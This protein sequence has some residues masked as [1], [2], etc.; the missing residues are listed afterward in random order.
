MKKR[1][2]K[3]LSSLMPKGAAKDRIKL[4]FYNF[5]AKGK[6]SFAI[7]YREGRPLY[8]TRYAKCNFTTIDPLYT[9]SEDFDF[10]QHYHKVTTGDIVID[11]GANNGYISLLF[12]KLAGK[13]GM[14]YAFEPDSINIDTIKLNIA[15]NELG[16][17]ISIQ[18]LLLWN[19]NILVDFYEA[20]SV[21]SSAVWMPDDEKVVKKN[22]VTIDDWV[23][24]NGISKLDFVKMDIEGAEIQALEG[25]VETIR[26]L[27]PDFA[28][29][30]YHI[31]DGQP[32][33]IKLEEFFKSINYPYKTVKFK[34][35]EII[36]FAGNI[37]SLR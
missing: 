30:S 20:G 13:S 25:C 27:K 6:T 35:N 15:L 7:E 33:F 4:A 10:Y 2:K 9:I 11:A 26:T 29:A 32:T 21:G 22:A 31:V 1:I 28:I 24:Q 36:T 17:D 12:S 18:E 5:A 16:A 8:K 23:A 14:V 34:K 19:E 37:P 3:I